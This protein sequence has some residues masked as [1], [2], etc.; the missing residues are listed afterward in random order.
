MEYNNIMDTVEINEELRKVNAIHGSLDETNPMTFVILLETN[1]T[2]FNHAQ[3]LW[4]EEMICILV[5][6]QKKRL[7]ASLANIDV[8]LAKMPIL[9]KSSMSGFQK[10]GL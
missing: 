5:D 3:I 9:E 2:R 1:R 8:E 4:I 7:D 10:I 6:K